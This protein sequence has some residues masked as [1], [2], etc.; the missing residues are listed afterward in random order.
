MSIT[1]NYTPPVTFDLPAPYYRAGSPISLIC[2][3]NTYWVSVA[4][5]QWSSSCSRNCFPLDIHEKVASTDYLQSSDSGLHTCEVH[6]VYGDVQSVNVTIDVVSKYLTQLSF[7][8]Y[9]YEL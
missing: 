6:S 3:V 1:V 2:E 7:A 9:I 4:F 5:Y 8:I